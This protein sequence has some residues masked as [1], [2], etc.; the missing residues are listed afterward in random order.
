MESASQRPLLSPPR[1]FRDV[2]PT[3]A[4]ELRVIEETLTETFA[5][6]GYM[7]LEPPMLEY[8][9]PQPARE[10]LIQFLDTDGSL[11]AL[12]PD[13]TTAVARLVAQ[14]YRETAGA[15]RLSYFAPVFREQPAM[16]ATEREVV[17]AGGALT[18]APGAIAHAEVLAPPAGG[19]QNC[20]PKLA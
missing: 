9:A 15:L 16:T 4:R 10:R 20:G 5:A 8:S 3:E 7:P 19:V 18:G 6:A 11:V 14:S 12:R 17:Q 1:G 13:L 2:L